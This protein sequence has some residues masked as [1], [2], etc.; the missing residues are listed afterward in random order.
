MSIQNEDDLHKL[1]RPELEARFMRTMIWYH[2][3]KWTPTG[4]FRS[5]PERAEQIATG[6]EHIA[7]QLAELNKQLAAGTVSQSRLATALNIFTFLLVLVGALQLFLN[8]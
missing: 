8:K 7:T 3:E 5:L 6:A 1:S 2:G 4:F